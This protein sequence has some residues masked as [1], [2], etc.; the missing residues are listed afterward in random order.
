MPKYFS[1]Y[2][3]ENPLNLYNTTPFQNSLNEGPLNIIYHQG[4]R[5][6]EW[7][8]SYNAYSFLENGSNKAINAFLLDEISYRLERYLIRS[9]SFGMMNSMEIRS[10]F[11]YTPI[12]KMA[13]N[14]PIEYKIKKNLFI[15]KYEQKHIVKEVAKRYGVPKTISN[16]KKIGTPISIDASIVKL[17]KKWPLDNITE[18]LHIDRGT[19]I[20]VLLNSYDPELFRLRFSIL[21]MD[22][23]I[24][25]FING[26]PYE[27]LSERISKELGQ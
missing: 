4:R 1:R 22:M 5:L 6:Q 24:D 21:S 7:Q 8:R 9:D 25:M 26:V 16:R 11:L 27:Y 15:K 13:L 2:S 17:L 14:T 18:L 20:N 3:E 12:V 10:P 19:L 23:I